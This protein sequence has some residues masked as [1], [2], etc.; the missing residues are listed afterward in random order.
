MFANLKQVSWKFLGFVVLADY[1]L[2]SLAIL[3]FTTSWLDPVERFTKGLVNA[4]LMVNLVIIGLIGFALFVKP[5]PLRVGDAGLNFSNLKV[6]L[7]F[8]LGLWI[9]VQLIEAIF[10]LITTGQLSLTANWATFGATVI[11]GQVIGQL[12]GNALYEE[13]IYR[14]LVFPQL[15]LKFSCFKW[16]SSKP[17]WSLVAALIASQVLF[18]LRHIAVRLYEGTFGLELLLSLGI[19]TLLGLFFAL[20]YLRTKNLFVVIG[21]HS[22]YNAP[23]ALFAGSDP[24]RLLIVLLTCL[25]LLVWPHLWQGQRTK[26]SKPITHSFTPTRV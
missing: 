10:S 11:I 22:L 13:V 17:G 26:S 23:A 8:T 3:V 12:F 21:I 20:V 9:I 7:L 2:V 25:L 5:G 18:A 4:T 24:S 16:F 19:V 1:I 15:Q 6:G 14:G